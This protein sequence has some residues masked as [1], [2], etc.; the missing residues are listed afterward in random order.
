MS[1]KLNHQLCFLLYANSRSIIKLYK[2]LL[3]PHK[4]TYTQY[5]T[6]LAL[7]DKDNETLK[8]LG[9]RLYLDSGTLTPVIKKLEKAEYVKKTRNTED[10]RRVIITLTQK[11]K[12]MKSVLSY[13]PTTLAKKLDL[14]QEEGVNLFKNL[15][16]LLSIMNK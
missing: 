6:L 11:G 14:S 5:I 13:I 2:P 10:E 9:N 7:W 1:Q 16:K 8:E 15:N 3:D 12:K 4:L